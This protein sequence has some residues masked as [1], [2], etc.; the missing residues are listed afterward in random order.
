[1]SDKDQAQKAKTPWI[2]MI[3]VA[4]FCS[5]L[6]GAGVWYVTHQEIAEKAAAGGIDDKKSKV[7]VVAET[8][9]YL[10]I[11][12]FTVNIK[13]DDRRQRL[14]YSGVSFKLGNAET[15]KFLNEHMVEIRSRLLMLVA[16]SKAEDLVTPEGKAILTGKIMNMFTL[17]FSAPQPELVVKEVLFTDFIVQ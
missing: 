6:T 3:A 17:P 14:L 2:P 16:D 10:K 12:P 11:A 9:I 15:E 1:M 5:G 7:P 13:S 8:P 4:L